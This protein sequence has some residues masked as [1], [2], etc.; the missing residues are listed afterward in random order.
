MKRLAFSLIACMVL[1][2]AAIPS[3]QAANW[4][5]DKR[6]VKLINPFGAG[7]TGDVELRVIAPLLEAKIGVPVVVENLTG[8]GGRIC[9][10]K[11]FKA[12]ADG[13]TLVYANMPAANLGEQL[14]K[15]RYKMNEFAFIA[16]VVQEYRFV[17]V[18]SNSPYK[19]FKDLF[20]ASKTE[21]LTCANSGLGSSGHL[22]SVLLTEKVGLK[23]DVVPFDGNA[24][25]KAAF[26]GGHVDFWMPGHTDVKALVKE[27]KIT[28]LAALAPHR[29]KNYEDVPTLKELGYPNVPIYTVRGLVGPSG[30]APQ[31]Q[32]KIVSAFKEVLTEA[33]FLS[34]AE[35]VERPLNTV[36]GDE[37][38]DLFEQT[39]ESIKA[40]LPT[41]QKSIGS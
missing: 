11:N 32:D 38:K 10:E 2:A 20:E 36:F 23:H 16:N 7:G 30:M 1:T 4:P 28:L 3:A 41:M 18:T 5:A 8:A 37:Y 27:G 19:T 35:G 22:G 9:M 40:V 14:Y 25:A 29:L 39:E 31:L 17:A 13:H 21:N 12:K 34:W 33:K 24:P 15:G 26:L 6:P